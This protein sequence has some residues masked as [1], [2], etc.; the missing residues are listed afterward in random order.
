MTR[1]AALAAL[2]L[3]ALGFAA[4]RATVAAGWRGMVVTACRNDGN[5]P[6]RC[7]T[8]APRPGPERIVSSVVGATLQSPAQVRTEAPRASAQATPDVRPEPVV[9]PL[10][11]VGASPTDTLSEPAPSGM[12][13]LKGLASW[14][15]RTAASPC[16]AGIPAGRLAAA[17]GPAL[18]AALGVAWRGRDVTVC[19]GAYICAT[20]TLVDWCQ[21]YGSRVLDLY[22]RAFRLLGDPTW[23]VGKLDAR[24]RVVPD[25][26]D[27]GLLALEVRW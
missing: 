25:P 6:S 10:P 5:N 9:G 12:A 19:R 11:P 27:G 3:L 8:A 22:A 26:L 2:L 4:G 7:V 16:T 15:C 13:A 21:C 23:S 20:V 17:A 18:R 24:G 14:Y 1:R